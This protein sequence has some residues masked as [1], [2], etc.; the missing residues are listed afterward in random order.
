QGMGDL[1]RIVAAGQTV[2]LAAAATP[3]ADGEAQLNQRLRAAALD[4]GLSD[5]LLSIE[6]GQPQQLRDHDLKD[7]PIFLQLN[8]VALRQLVAFLRRLTEDDPHIV[9]RNISLTA[10]PNA[11]A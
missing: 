7:T 10:P 8:G 11:T 1:Q 5:Q 3:A 2:S 6:P 4:A 9:P